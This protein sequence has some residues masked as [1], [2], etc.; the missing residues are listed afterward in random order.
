MDDEEVDPEDVAAALDDPMPQEIEL[1][2]DLSGGF[3]LW[4]VVNDDVSIVLRTQ[5][6]IELKPAVSGSHQH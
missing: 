4:I 1:P 2:E 5:N 6:R 3:V